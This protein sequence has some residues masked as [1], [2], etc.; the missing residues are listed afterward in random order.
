MNPFTESPWPLSPDDVVHLLMMTKAAHHPAGPRPFV[1]EI[2]AEWES[3]WRKGQPQPSKEAAATAR[4]ST[5]PGA[6]TALRTAYTGLTG[7]RVEP[8]HPAVPFNHDVACA[9]LLE[10]FPGIALGR[11]ERDF[12]QRPEI[13]AIDHMIGEANRS[14]DDLHP[15][16]SGGMVSQGWR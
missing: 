9:R 11:P 8:D 15:L 6:V 4:W 3:R 16:S 14:R 12:S 13:I 10:A 1:G 7:R 5:G 2:A